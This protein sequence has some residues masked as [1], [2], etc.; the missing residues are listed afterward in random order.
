MKKKEY[1]T[2]NYKFVVILLHGMYGNSNEFKYLLNCNKF[3]HIKFILLDSPKQDI[4]WPTGIEKNVKSWYNYYTDY[5]GVNKFDKISIND[6]NNITKQ[7]H[8][9][10]DTEIN[11]LKDPSKIIIGGSSQGGTVAFHAALTYP[12]ILGGVISLR[13]ILLDNTV[14]K[15]TNNKLNFF[16]FCAEKDNVYIPKLYNRSF[17][18]LENSN[19]QI[20]KH[21]QKDLDHG[22]NSRDEKQF[23]IKSIIDLCLS[24]NHL[25]I[26]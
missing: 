19:Y 5:S 12:E 16:I 1:N 20:I 24:S 26:N 6:L 15:P 4:N 17:S 22:S 13:S 23:T 2:D 10:I 9:L 18:R 7:I 21:I 3:E 11:I 14:V 8:N 25:S